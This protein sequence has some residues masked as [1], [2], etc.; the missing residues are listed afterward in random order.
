MSH[1]IAWRRAFTLV[2]LLVVIAIIGILVALLLPA[3]Q[4]AREAARRTNCLNK[5]KQIGLALQ[6]YHDVKK[7]FPPGASGEV[8]SE[9]VPPN[10][11]RLALLGY[12]PHILPYM[13]SGN[14]YSQMSLKCHWDL[15]PNKTVAANNPV[16]EFHCPSQEEFQN[17][18]FQPAGSSGSESRSNLMAHYHGVMGARPSTC[19]PPTGSANFPDST[20]TVFV[21]PAYSNPPGHTCGDGVNGSYGPSASNG[22]IYPTSKTNMRD[23]TDGTSHTFIVGE[24]SWNAGPQRIWSVAGGANNNLDTFEYTC[25]N[26]YW[27]LNT[28]CRASPTLVEPPFNC[29]YANNDMSFGSNHPGGC[30]FAMCDAS[31]QFV[32]QDIEV[33][34]LKALASRKSAETFDPPF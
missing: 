31:V 28:A 34:I 6:N 15:E 1:R 30:H 19:P 25:K 27:P 23:I 32:K 3:V 26:I 10:T 24:L 7:G 5:M 17:T 9:S 14:L 2:E 12:I 13:E 16:V 20:Y 18:F 33:A 8:S 29:P 21:S 22:V 4:S 11:G